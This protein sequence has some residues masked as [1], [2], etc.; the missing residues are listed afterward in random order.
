MFLAAAAPFEGDVQVAPRPCD[1]HAACADARFF[2]FSE[3]P[4]GNI[5]KL[6]MQPVAFH[7]RSRT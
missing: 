1:V 7:V 2:G 3:T 5:V 4:V 6:G